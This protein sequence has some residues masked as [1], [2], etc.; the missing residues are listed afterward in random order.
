MRFCTVA[1]VAVAAV[2]AVTVAVI[3]IDVLVIVVLCP[4][5][6]VLLMLWSLLLRLP[7]RRNFGFWL[8]LL[9]ATSASWW[10][11]TVDQNKLVAKQLQS[12]K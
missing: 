1:V 12:Q 6:A 11:S 9:Y 4:G 2:A 3:V 5:V 7:T 8:C 10:I